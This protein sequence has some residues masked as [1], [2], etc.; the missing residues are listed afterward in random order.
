MN[1]QS[2]HNVLV[3]YLMENANLRIA[4]EDL[5]ARLAELEKQVGGD[6]DGISE[7]NMA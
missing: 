6:K 5:K 1:D 2:V 4:N 3:Q 7:A